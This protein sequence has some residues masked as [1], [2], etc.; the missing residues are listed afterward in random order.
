LGAVNFP[1][2][3]VTGLGMVS[4][5]GTGAE[6]TFRRLCAGERGIRPVSLFDPLDARSKLA[7]EVPGLD[8][9][10]IAP[11]GDDDWSRTD[12]MALVA[13]R[14]ALQQARAHGRLGL[15]I[16]GT[17]GGMLETEAALVGGSLER[18]EPERAR[19]LLDHPLDR[20]AT[21]LAGVLGAVRHSTL[22][23]AC[24]S[25]AVSLARAISWLLRGEVDQVLA[26]GA[27]GLCR[28]T[29]FGFD[30][31]AALDPEPCRPFDRA[32]RGLTLGEGAAFLVLEREP[33]ARARGAEILG[34]FSGASI[35][36]E[37]HHIT[38]PE[39]SGARSAELMQR[40][41]RSAR[42]DAS[43]IDYVNA[44]GTGTPPNDAM[45]AR[46]IHAAFGEHAKNV[47]VSS[48]KGQLGHAL[49]AAGALEAAIT[50]LALARHTAPPNAG[51]E[52][53]EDPTL[54]YV[55]GAAVQAPLRAAL[56]C[57]F[58]FGGTGAVL[59]FERADAP[60]RDEVG[61]STLHRVARAAVTGNALLVQGNVLESLDPER[62]RRFGRAAAMVTHGAERALA[63]AGLDASMAGLVAGS[64][65]GSVERS[66]EFVRRVLEKG[67]RRANPAEFP[68]L[69]ASAAPG[70]ASLYLGL[71]GPVL[72][73]AAGEGSAE[74]ALDTALALLAFADGGLV[75]GA[76]EAL[77]PIVTAVLGPLR[78][79]SG[80]VERGEGG[81]FLVVEALESA[82]ERGVA[83]RVLVEHPR[84]VA[85]GRRFDDV[86]PPRDTARAVVVTGALTGDALGSLA[87]SPWGSATRRSA[88]ELSGY[89][90][91]AGG[92]ALVLAATLVASG[93]FDDALACNGREGTWVTRFTRAESA[94]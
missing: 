80:V 11:V 38:Q 12:A 86:L 88:L 91:A 67:V 83:P 82:Q 24:A 34:F 81:G 69:V 20:T 41:L 18:V 22:C 16:G 63:D 7:A 15:S 89:H 21:R 37:A 9:R 79:K 27:D 44:H 28:L 93:D 78:S 43:S 90:E 48:S 50:V 73:A 57:S 94:A 3:A 23:A 46:A 92:L 6:A 39:P 62:T 17:T 85:G 5:L 76:A 66:V 14:E 75:A 4:A 13:A 52:D 51:L 61:G 10:A 54:R 64:A 47:L 25:G 35:A 74:S 58:G 56:S 49:G 26:G 19:R 30:S 70:N 8:V 68:H 2:L 53:P 45:E 72:G 40:A 65:Y 32:R 60:P 36:A 29:F 71:H 59:V 77:D 31:L 87:R 33:A 84:F 1:R 55:P 42:L